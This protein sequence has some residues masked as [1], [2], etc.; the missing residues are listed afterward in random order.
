[1]IAIAAIIGVVF[2][3]LELAAA[4]AEAAAAEAAGAEAAATE[5]AAGEIAEVGTSEVTIAENNAGHIFRE[6]AG[7]LADTPANRKLL[8]DM[9]SKAENYLGK[10]SFGNDWYAEMRSDGSQVWAS[11]RNGQIRN[12]GF[13]PIAR[14]WTPGTGLSRPTKP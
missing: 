2:I 6:E 12:G 9:A 14:D 4:A 13:N 5:T 8:T 11:V 7:H 1:M 3:G 10:D